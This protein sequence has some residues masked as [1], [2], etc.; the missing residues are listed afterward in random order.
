M[1]VSTTIDVPRWIDA[2]KLSPIQLTVF[3]LCFLMSALDGFDAQVMGYVAPAIGREFHLHPEQM[4]SVFASGLAGLLVGCLLIAPMADWLGRKKVL[5]GSALFFGLFSLATTQASGFESLLLLRF[6]TGLGLGGAM[7]N[8][9][10]LTAEYLPA[11]RRAAWTMAMFVGFPVG[12]TIGGLIAAPLIPAY[13]WQ[14][15]FWIGGVLPILFAGVMLVG[16]PESIRHLVTRGE[17]PQAVRAILAR[18]DKTTLIPADARFVINEEKYPGLTVSHLFSGNR[19]L[20]TVLLWVIFFMSLLDIFFISSWLPTVLSSAGMAESSAVIATAMV[21][22][23]GVVTSLLVG[24]WVDR[25]GFFVILTPLYLLAAVSIVC[26][27]QPGLPVGV[28]MAAAALSGAGIVGGQ[29]AVN[30]LAAV[31]YPT[32]MRAT[33]VGW[34]LGIGRIGSIVGPVIGGMLI[35]RHWGNNDLFLAA[36]LP[37]LA[38]ALATVLMAVTNGKRVSA[39]QADAAVVVSH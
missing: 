4:G 21:Q 20:G 26:L 1:R 11:N 24:R 8:G 2:R 36:A 28:I 22:G 19:A 31:Y 23:G 13:G 15:I 35:A 27:G 10:A 34:G 29:T 30:V 33:G 39:M 14:I 12:A 3:T 25:F 37:A 16:L 9:I 5:V 32:F 38:A 7:P 18:I 17:Q 6:I